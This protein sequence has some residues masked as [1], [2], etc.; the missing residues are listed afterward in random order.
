MLTI[1][2]H[3]F[4]D[5]GKKIFVMISI[6]VPCRKEHKFRDIFQACSLG[7]YLKVHC[8]TL[9]KEI[10]ISNIARGSGMVRVI[11]DRSI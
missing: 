5:F 4:F 10:C 3:L 1:C 11:C 8:E 7:M 9:E 6:C 2:I